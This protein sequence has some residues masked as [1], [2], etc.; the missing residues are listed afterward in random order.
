MWHTLLK[1]TS[2]WEYNII[3]LFGIITH[4]NYYKSEIEN[5]VIKTHIFSHH[6]HHAFF[7]ILIIF[8]IFF[9]SLQS[10]LT[11]LYSSSNFIFFHFNSDKS[12]PSMRRYR[13][14]KSLVFLFFCLTRSLDFCVLYLWIYKFWNNI[15][16]LALFDSRSSHYFYHC[17]CF[18]I[19]FIYIL[20]IYGF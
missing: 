6:K 13:W 7:K 9:F 16:A 2:H 20:L 12:Y 14:Q 8:T 18:S 11:Y 5:E 15:I 17:S 4:F 19:F 10:L 1:Y 3:Y